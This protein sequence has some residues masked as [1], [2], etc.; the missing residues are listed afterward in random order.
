MKNLWHTEVREKLTINRNF[1]KLGFPFRETPA[2]PSLSPL[3][4]ALA[5]ASTLPAYILAVRPPFSVK[6]VPIDSSR[7]PL[8]FYS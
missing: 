8:Q 7:Y 6:P 1:W 2:Q 5:A 3:P 4:I